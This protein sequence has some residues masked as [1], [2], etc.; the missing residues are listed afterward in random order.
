M[1]SI[2]D[3]DLDRI[4]CRKHPSVVIIMM[5]RGGSTGDLNFVGSADCGCKGVGREAMDSFFT[6]LAPFVDCS[7]KEFKEFLNCSVLLAGITDPLLLLADCLMI[8][9]S[10]M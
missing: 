4:R 3:L 7:D 5:G 10:K 8:W 1:V 2:L 9:L 6:K